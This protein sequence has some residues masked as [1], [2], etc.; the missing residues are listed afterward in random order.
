MMSNTTITIDLE[1]TCAECRKKGA[2]V[3]DNGLC[4]GCTTKAI[5]GKAM[6]SAQGA[7]VAARFDDLKRNQRPVRENGPRNHD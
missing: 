3:A 1:K 4:L 7:A 2:G 6:R 5:K